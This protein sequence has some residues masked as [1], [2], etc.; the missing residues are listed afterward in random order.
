MVGRIGRPHGVRG[1]VT[2]EVRTDEGGRYLIPGLVPGEYQVRFTDAT[3]P[4]GQTWAQTGNVILNPSFEF[5]NA[6]ASPAAWAVRPFCQL[7]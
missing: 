7:S 4:H 3:G 5:A 1:E 2:V 6:D